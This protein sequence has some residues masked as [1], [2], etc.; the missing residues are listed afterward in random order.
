MIFIGRVTLSLLLSTSQKFV[1]SSSSLLHNFSA[2]EPHSPLESQPTQPCEIDRNLE[3][4]ISLTHLLALVNLCNVPPPLKK[5]HST[6]FAARIHYIFRSTF[7]YKSD[8]F[9]PIQS[10]LE[11]AFPNLSLP[12]LASFQ[13]QKTPLCLNGW[14]S[15]R[16]LHWSLGGVIS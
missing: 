5:T 10:T 2:H 14:V 15:W 8:P 1:S 16:S 6:S 13:A 12:L 3:V 7:Q 11:R 9:I 4:F